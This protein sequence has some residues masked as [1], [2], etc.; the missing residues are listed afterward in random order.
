MAFNTS[1]GLR[2]LSFLTSKDMRVLVFNVILYPQEICFQLFSSWARESHEIKSE[3]YCGTG[4][5]LILFSTSETYLPG[6]TSWE[7]VADDLLRALWRQRT[8]LFLLLSLWP[9]RVFDKGLEMPVGSQTHKVQEYDLPALLPDP[10]LPVCHTLIADM[11]SLTA[12]P[13][14]SGDQW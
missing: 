13:R 14:Q 5:L 11:L 10:F 7:V 4:F 6:C 3:V 8:S 9:S 12:L 1:A 2:V